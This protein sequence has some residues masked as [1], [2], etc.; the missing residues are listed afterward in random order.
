VWYTE[1]LR[2]QR[3]VRLIFDHCAILQ[4]DDVVG[5]INDE[6]ADPECDEWNECAKSPQY[7]Y[8]SGVAPMGLPHKLVSDGA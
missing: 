3:R 8:G 2:Y 5:H 7:N 4:N 1:S 6:I